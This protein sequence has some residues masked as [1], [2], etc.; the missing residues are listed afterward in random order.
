MWAKPRALCRVVWRG[1][2]YEPSRSALVAGCIGVGV[3]AI[4]LARAFGAGAAAELEAV[5]DGGNVVTVAAGRVA[6]PPYRGGGSRVSTRLRYPDVETLSAD[7]GGIAAAAAVTEAPRAITLGGA[8]AVASVRGVEPSY[9]RLRGFRL[10]SG[11]PFDALDGQ[12]ASRVAIVGAAVAEALEPDAHIVGRTI[13]IAGVP[14]DVIGVL[15]PRGLVADT[16]SEDVQV[17]IPLETAARRL[18]GTDSLSAILLDVPDPDA[19]ERTRAAV[20]SL[21]RANHGLGEGTPDDFDVLLPIRAARASRAQ[22]EFLKGLTRLFSAVTVVI[23]GLAV[24]IMTSLN[25]S[26]RTWEVGLRLAIG[27]R[28]ID[29]ACLHVLEACALSVLGG[30]AGALG[31]GL[32]AVVIDALTGA[33]VRLEPGFVALLVLGSAA[34]GVAFGAGPAIVASRLTPVAALNRA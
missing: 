28:R 9:L 33:A 29:I 31:A 20:R 27:A 24:L 4:G 14:F 1:V 11:R 2:G 12:T 10:G 30:S 13:H 6:V 25:V 15:E 34:L 26:D 16:S 19:A 17:L 23:G 22:A 32:A 3:A 8:A 7:V 21:L 5:Q 18:F